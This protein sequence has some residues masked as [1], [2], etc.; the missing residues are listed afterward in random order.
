MEAIFLKLIEQ[1]NSSVVILLMV[2]A[3][4]FFLIY[5]LGCLVTEFGIFREKN[6]GFDDGMLNIKSDLSE[7]KATAKLLYDAHLST[8]KS[9]S[10]I[11]LTSKGEII[12]N[13]VG[14]KRKVDDHW[15][16][17][18]KILD[19]KKPTNPYD[20]QTVAM[21]AAKFIFDTVF[22]EE[23]KNEIKMY[24][25]NKGENILQITPIIGV[26]SRDRYLLEKGYHKDEIDSHDPGNHSEK[27]M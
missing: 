10:P 9:H 18:K 13:E 5:K 8:I 23:E 24:A 1:L 16:D 3:I 19:E 15:S 27:R 6:K 20:I 11:S 4:A 14:M 12:S 26:L 25:Y 2:L 7:I 17:I 21:D 22:T